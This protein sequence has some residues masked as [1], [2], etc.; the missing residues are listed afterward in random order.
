M[1]IYLKSEV[2]SQDCLLLVISFG[3]AFVFLLFS[4]GVSSNL[5]SNIIREALG[6][7]SR[8]AFDCLL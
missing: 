7:C 4:P 8:V 1:Q 2:H 3:F 6:F 5:K